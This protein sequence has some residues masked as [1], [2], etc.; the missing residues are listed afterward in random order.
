MKI[1]KSVVIFQIKILQSPKRLD[2]T[3]LKPE[4]QCCV[5]EYLAI[6]FSKISSHVLN[7][8]GLKSTAMH[9]C[10]F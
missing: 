9:I 6:Q 8:S 7:V 2:K 3:G 10:M 5:T 4:G 1:T